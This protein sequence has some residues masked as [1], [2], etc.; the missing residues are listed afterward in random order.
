[1]AEMEKIMNQKPFVSKL[2][3]AAVLMAGVGGL[4]QLGADA[5]GEAALL[6]QASS[7][8]RQ[9]NDEGVGYYQQEQWDMAKEYFQI[10]VM[11]DPTL[12]EAHYN[13]ALALDKLGKHKD[14]AVH[15]QKALEL[16][17]ENPAIR[18]SAILKA[19]LRE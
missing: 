16:A 2:L 5:G 10:A 11:G 14:A 19:H 4:G 1:M 7:P 9:D 6:T 13:L 18:D 3:L 15:F 8:A 12:A 17:P